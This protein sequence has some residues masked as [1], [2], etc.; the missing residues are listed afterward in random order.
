M[1]MIRRIENGYAGAFAASHGSAD[2]SLSIMR[3]SI[4]YVARKPRGHFKIFKVVLP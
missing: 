4:R 3:A 2:G 1:T